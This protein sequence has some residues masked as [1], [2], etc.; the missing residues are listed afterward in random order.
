MFQIL[1]LNFLDSSLEIHDKAQ[2]THVCQPFD[3]LIGVGSR[4]KTLKVWVL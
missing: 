1:L 4:S 3:Y 2:L